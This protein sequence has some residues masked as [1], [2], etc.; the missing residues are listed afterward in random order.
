MV[1]VIVR[2]LLG[3]PS[4]GY[5]LT[6]PEAFALAR[7][8]RHQL[9]ELVKAREEAKKLVK[10]STGSMH[11]VA[12]EVAKKRY[13]KEIRESAKQSQDAIAAYEKAVDEAISKVTNPL[14]GFVEQQARSMKR[15]DIL[16]NIA[17]GVAASLAAGAK[18]FISGAAAVVKPSTY[19]SI[20]DV[21]TNPLDTYESLKEQVCKPFG[22]SEL[23]GSI[24]AQ[25]LIGYGVGRGIGKIVSKVRPPS[26]VTYYELEPETSR[27]A[28]TVSPAKGGRFVLKGVYEVSGKGVKVKNPFTNKPVKLPARTEKFFTVKG[29]GFALRYETAGKSVTGMGTV[30]LTSEGPKFSV[31]KASLSTASLKGG[32]LIVREYVRRVLSPTELSELM[33]ELREGMKGIAGRL[34]PSRIEVVPTASRGGQQTLTTLLKRLGIEAGRKVVAIRESTNIPNIGRISSISLPTVTTPKTVRQKTSTSANTVYHEQGETVNIISGVGRGESIQGISNVMGSP[35]G[36]GGGVS[37]T[38]SGV[39]AS[40]SAGYTPRPHGLEFIS[41]EP[42]D[43]S[44]ALIPRPHE[45]ERVV[46][47][48][49]VSFRAKPKPF[50]I[51]EVSPDNFIKDIISPKRLPKVRPEEIVKPKIKPSLGVKP[52][53]K[54]IPRP[55]EIIR[56][57]PR[58]RLFKLPIEKLKPEEFTGEVR[59]LVRGFPRR[60]TLRFMRRTV[61]PETEPIRIPRRMLRGLGITLTTQRIEGFFKPARARA[62]S[63]ASSKPPK[64]SSK[65]EFRF[66]LPSGGRKVKSRGR[67]RRKSYVEYVN[68]FNL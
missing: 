62:L 35:E 52:E 55:H 67:R 23:V 58:E 29:G 1:R 53:S 49:E 38:V 68:P 46:G 11:S 44:E 7:A 26:R 14:Q 43:F 9:E 37:S 18:G 24:G 6:S 57:K 25:V 50:A 8:R 28:V 41:S 12:H 4:G 66:Q 56:P 59:E 19:T 45:I 13:G 2:R 54:L 40:L 20:V 64:S 21:V 10:A 47:T 34:R 39:E 15:G 27:L 22:V 65:L 36:V 42:I 48:P 61:K 3:L 51:P 63:K 60:F 16:G 30:E 33:G 5:S 31:G 17:K 32:K